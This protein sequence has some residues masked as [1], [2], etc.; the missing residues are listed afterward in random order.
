MR[1][2]VRERAAEKVE[3]QEKAAAKGKG[4]QQQLTAVDKQLRH[5]QA[6]HMRRAARLAR[7]RELAN[8]KGDA[9]TVARI[10]KLTQREQQRYER[11]LGQTERRRQEIQQMAAGAAGKGP[12]AAEK[13]GKPASRKGKGKEKVKAEKDEDKDEDKQEEAEQEQEK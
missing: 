3:A 7:L 1:K 12:E 10:N 8:A 6:K 13:L 9:E 5:E 4:H 2:R 11:K